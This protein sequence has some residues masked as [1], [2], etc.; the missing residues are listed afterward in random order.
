[1]NRTVTLLLCSTAMAATTFVVAVNVRAKDAPQGA[2]LAVVAG[3]LL[4]PG[5]FTFAAYRENKA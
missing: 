1:M 5:A 4:L 3:L 2:T